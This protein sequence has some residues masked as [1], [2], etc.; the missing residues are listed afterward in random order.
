[1]VTVEILKDAFRK[2]LSY[3][4]YDKTDMIMRRRVA[5]FAI[6]LSPKSQEDAVFNSL[7]RVA[8]GQD[9]E[10]LAAWLDQMR[11]VFYPKSISKRTDDN[12]HLITNI[13]CD[14]AE[15]ERLLI[16]VDIPIEL[17][18]LDVAWLLEYGYRIDV[19][20]S[21]NSWGNRLELNANKSGVKRG[22]ALFKKYQNQYGLWWRKGLAKA[23]ERL[24]DK[25]NVSIISFDITNCYHSI[26]FNFEDFFV[27]YEAKRRDDIR[28]S[29]LTNVIIRTYERYWGL[30]N[31]CGEE[32]FQ[33]ANLGKH[34]LPLSLMSAHIFAN[35]YLKPLDEYIERVHNP[36]YYGRYVDDCMVAVNTNSD[37]ENW[38]ESIN[39]EM[40]GLLSFEGETVHFAF[41]Q[42]RY[43]APG[44]ERNNRLASLDIQ[45]K[46]VYV[47]RF[48]CMLPPTS[49]E[50]FEADQKERTSEF[51]FLTDDADTGA[52]SLE[53]V[54]LIDALDANEESGR[55]FN[56]LEENKYRL[57][58]YLAKLA[59]RLAKFG[60]DY[61]R[62][63]EVDKISRYF[64]G[65]L[66]IK[67]YVLWE[68]MMAVFVLAD[69]KDYLD[70]FVNEVRRVI[71]LLTIKDGLFAYHQ[72]EGLRTL[73][74]SLLRHL[75]E[76]WTMALSLYKETAE[77]G[78]YYQKSFMVRMHYN[79][80][81]LQ[82]FCV[83]FD[84]EGA[85]LTAKGL[86]Y[87]KSLWNYRWMPYYVKYY[88][89]V[90]MLS[91][92]ESYDP[93]VFDK[94]FKI[95][96]ILNHCKPYIRATG[97]WHYFDSN[98]V[99]EFN[100]H[101]NVEDDGHGDFNVAVVNMD[102]ENTAGTQ[103][104]KDF[105][106]VKSD[107]A[108]IMQKILDKISEIGDIQLFLL[109][110]MSLPLYELREYCQYASKKERAFVAGMEYYVSKKQVYNYIITCL[111]IK[112][113]G[114][115]D[116]VPVIRL[117]NHY[118]PA[119]YTSIGQQKMSVPSNSKIY[120]NLYHWRDHVFTTYYCYELTSIRERSF[121][122]SKID[123]MYCPVF[124]PDTF[125]FNNIAESMVRDMHCY[126]ILSNV[127][128]FGDS[129]VTAPMKHDRMNLLKV[130]GGNTDKNKAIVLTAKLD[131]D[132]I[133]RFQAMTLPQQQVEMKRGGNDAWKMT[134]PDYSKEDLESR[135]NRSFV[136]PF[137]DPID[138]FIADLNR[139]ILEY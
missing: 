35:W 5:E 100:P 91:L 97:F 87:K 139:M 63:D 28:Q 12:S 29:T 125:Y 93:Y 117:K 19:G 49:L 6:S 75:E 33:G 122:Y 11:M 43:E 128:H 107:K 121:F 102:L 92:G 60:K 95:Y 26:D 74:E 25:E 135:T 40:P 113:Y 79:T 24:K 70:R 103:Q 9:E 27:E 58:V 64:K 34:P 109:P 71:P 53:S 138:G 133:R 124:N 32:A 13:P 45:K 86:V 52:V 116:A 106:I 54:T 94:A 18:I 123:A 129:R 17:C 56:I 8:Q 82:E 16:K 62:Y 39:E 69:R 130:K 78:T 81:P 3:S 134:P 44:N 84:K 114:R 83:G 65:E 90:M 15:V 51:R 77:I 132:D 98:G 110:E 20:L 37:S 4:Y 38:E 112:L 76:S 126:F 136:Y 99:S 10:T 31:E 46:K 101:L 66:L 89:I 42:Q 80:L 137:E 2:L 68:R 14:N 131:I 59:A 104:I 108:L 118:A 30:T 36:L 47:Y 67:H 85:K 55:R 111:P 48:D 50:E 41:A 127:S 96:T 88:D 1:M 7:L 22:N 105:G 115:M 120:Q 57:A 73:R 72:E 119:E 61:P 23:N 21:D